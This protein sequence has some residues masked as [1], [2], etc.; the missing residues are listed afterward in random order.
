[1]TLAPGAHLGP[2]EILSAI[3]AG[4]MGEV[5]RARDP[6][7][8][9]DVAI[10]VLPAAFSADPDRLHRFEVEARAAAALNHPNILAVYDLGTH[11]GAP[12]I[13]SELLQGETLRTR[14]ARGPGRTTPGT[15]GQPAVESAGAPT[16]LAVRKATDYAVQIARGLAAAHDKGIVH[17]DLKPENVFVTTDGHLKILDFGL[18]KLTHV[19]AAPV[20]LT[21]SPTKLADTQ[22][23]VLLGTMGYM[24]P[25]Q[26][27]GQ[28]A[29]HRADIFAFGAML[30]ELLAGRRAFWGATVADT[31]SAILDKDPPELSLADR[32]IPPGLARIVDRC[33]E[34]DPAARFQSTRDLTFALE[35]LDSHSSDGPAAPAQA[36]HTRER[37]WQV[38]ALL[39]VVAAIAL[40]G[41][42][43]GTR[44][45]APSPQ[46]PLPIDLDLGPDVS[47]ES[48]IGPAAIL[49]PDGTRLVFVSKGSD[50][51]SRLLTKRLDEPK[52]TVLP[53]TEGAY[54]P[55][56]RPDGQWV[57]FF[58]GGKLWK[59]R[60]DGGQPIA[61][62]DA[63][64]GRGASWSDDG[65]IIAALDVRVGLSRI[66]A[67][68]GQ[69]TSVT[70]VEPGEVGHRWPHVVPGGKAVLF[71]AN[72][73]PASYE[74]SKIVVVSLEGQQRK[75]VLEHAGMYPRYLPSGDVVFV[76]KGTLFA[77]PF[78][79]GR[80]AFSGTRRR[81]LEDVAS[82]LGFGSAQVDVS[83]NGTLLYHRGGTL[84]LMTIQWLDGAGN[85]KS[86]RQEPALYSAPRVSPDGSRLA[87]VVAEGSNAGIWVYN[88]RS[89][90]RTAVTS[91]PGVNSYPVWS[92]DGRYVVF[93]SPSSGILWAPADAAHGPRPFTKGQGKQW[94][95]S[96]TSDGT[97][98]AFFERAPDGGTLIQTVPV[99]GDSSEPQAGEP[100]L[101]LRTPSGNSY[102]AFSPD[103]RWLAYSSTD[104]G[105][106]EVYVR[107]FPDKGTKRLISNGG[108]NMP[109][110][111]SNGKDLFYRTDDQ[112]IMVASYTVTGGSFV[113]D[114]PRV[115]SDKRLANTGLSL[116]LDLAPDGKG[117]AVL[118]PADNPE[119][120]ETR[121]HV[122]LMLNFFD[123]LRR[124][125]PV[126]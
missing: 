110:W 28:P 104:S 97:R 22:P 41:W 70:T 95:T 82:D 106:Y 84:G 38:V 56:F 100:K 40:L 55:F 52:A 49:S 5:Y 29:D 61:L 81:V 8:N 47:F 64:A 31:V 80:L 123:E 76:T 6:R 19:E 53:G 58:A 35:A 73:V 122:T 16:G 27:R 91:G 113:H 71:M 24:A 98:L 51:V 69:P 36:R 39:T 103:G 117:F 17:R 34:K 60:V 118:M 121:G 63:P 50:D 89:G 32:H 30:Y 111:S 46:P 48:S 99:R 105:V 72:Y 65:S 23:G 4:G 96:F 83:R 90:T 45:T 126:K 87:V 26:A 109:M 115:W 37:A 125:A 66:P 12:Y 101:F 120:R 33:L 102:P 10:K 13:V 21:A 77:V 75:T 18:A 74:E 1:M 107:A 78:D 2:Y 68:G 124:L 108:G 79:L 94:P 15:S 93:Q 62:C 54:G 7:L 14:A 25:E 85:T 67:D 114:T 92:P 20:D 11:D 44:S 57:G 59:T 119:P 9:R 116:N 42:W 86:L 3:G 88:L 112:R 43:G